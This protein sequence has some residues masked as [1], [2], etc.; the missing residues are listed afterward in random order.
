MGRSRGGGGEGVEGLDPPFGK[1][2]VAIGFF[3]NSG[4]DPMRQIHGA[5]PSVKSVDD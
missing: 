4:M 3:K 5:G 1:S 2:Q